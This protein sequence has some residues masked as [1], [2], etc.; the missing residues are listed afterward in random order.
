MQ[1][2]F[3]STE[4]WPTA[5]YW[6]LHCIL[7]ISTRRKT[8]T[9]SNFNV[10]TFPGP[11]YVFL[12]GRRRVHSEGHVPNGR[13][14]LLLINRLTRPSYQL[15]CSSF[16][17]CLLLL[18][19]LIPMRVHYKTIP[20]AL[21]CWRLIVLLYEN[22]LSSSRFLP[23]AWNKVS[24][25]KHSDEKMFSSVSATH[26]FT[27]TERVTRC[28]P[29]Q[30]TAWSRFVSAV[31]RRWRASNTSFVSSFCACMPLKVSWNKWGR[32]NLTRLV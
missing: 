17:M 27:G 16:L 32:L 15:V 23:C 28:L 25:R 13:L 2:L 30:S 11:G 5:K 29:A 3:F 12:I 26:A 4:Q 18:R 19:I 14:C 20:L 31:R 6:S 7:L 8:W 22:T 21:P 1:C 24:S 10:L 9:N